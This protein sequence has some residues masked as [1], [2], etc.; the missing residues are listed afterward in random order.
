MKKIL[1]LVV[2]LV[3]FSGFANADSNKRMEAAGK[4]LDALM[5]HD[6][7]Q[8]SIEQMLEIQL[9]QNPE[10]VPYRKTMLAF[11]QKHMSYESMKDEMAAIYAEA[12]DEHELYQLTEFYLSPVGKKTMQKM[13]E[14]MAKG[15]RMGMARVQNNLGELQEM[16]R[17]ES[18]R[19]EKLQNQ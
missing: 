17:L 3:A 13:P 12:F 16:I 9:Q 11:F 8:K 6:L 18:E 14:L 10:M 5:M 4:L 1:I 15:A 19:V 2:V 7:L